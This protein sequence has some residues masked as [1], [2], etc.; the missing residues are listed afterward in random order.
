MDTERRIL[1]FKDFKGFKRAKDIRNTY[2]LYQPLGKG[3]FGEVRKATHIKANVDCAV[4]IIKKKAIQQHQ[5]LVDLMH[6][7]LK[8]LEETVSQTLKMNSDLIRA[9]IDSPPYYEN[10]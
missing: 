1:S 10:I 6:N 3:S 4:K 5:I 8:V 2:I 7:E 9:L